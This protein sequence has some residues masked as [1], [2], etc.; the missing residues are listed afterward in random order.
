MPSVE[1]LVQ[2]LSDEINSAKERLHSLQ[3]K[4][5]LVFHDQELRFMRFVALAERIR[6][7]FQPRIEALAKIYVF[8]DI[9]KSVS[10]EQQGPEGLGLH[11]ET[12][13]LAVPYSE[14]CPAKVVLSFRVS[15]D[16]AIEHAVIEYA[17]EI[18]PIYIK[19]DGHVQLLVPLDN[20]NDEAIA[21]WFDD[22]LVEFTRTYLELSFT[23]QYQKKNLETDPVMNV[24]FPRV[25]AAGKQEDHGRTYYFYTKESL[26]AFEKAPADYVGTTA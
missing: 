13:T 16:R 20:P 3:T 1:R 23:D 6:A 17:L 4:A 14:D 15:H 19:F 25:F 7:I 12:T 5:T 21:A 24:Q 9:K 11:E 22:R 18:L 2:R 10:L 8:K 26:Q